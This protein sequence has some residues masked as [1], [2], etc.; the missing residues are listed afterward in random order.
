[1]KWLNI[2]LNQNWKNYVKFLIQTKSC[3]ISNK[4][5]SIFFLIRK[6][7]HTCENT[8][9]QLCLRIFHS[10]AVDLGS[11]NLWTSFQFYRMLSVLDLKLINCLNLMLNQIIYYLNN[12]FA[13]FRQCIYRTS[14]IFGKMWFNYCVYTISATSSAQV[15]CALYLNDP[16]I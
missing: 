2:F 7:P 10:W 14:D 3:S 6:H 5:Y 1:M 12:H 4:S 13:N 11:W 16:E 15:I 8:I 9:F